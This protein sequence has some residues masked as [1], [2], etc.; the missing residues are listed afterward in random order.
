MASYGDKLNDERWQTTR[1]RILERDAYACH[2]CGRRAVQVHHTYYEYG[3]EPWEY[4]DD[5]LKS[6][7]EPCHEKADALRVWLRSQIGLLSLSSQRRVFGYAE[8]L[9][10]AEGARRPIQ[11]IDDE[12]CQG[13]ADAWGLDWRQVAAVRSRGLEIQQDQLE[14]L[15]RAMLLA[16]FKKQEASSA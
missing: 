11:A 6:V 10:L 15:K 12:M 4:P 14:A 7:C 5:S 3:L 1:L 16:R 13:I 9:W 8:S 2:G